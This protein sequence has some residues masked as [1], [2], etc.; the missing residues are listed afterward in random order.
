LPD[1]LPKKADRRRGDAMFRDLNG[2]YRRLPDPPPPPRRRLSKQEE[3]VMVWI[4]CINLV[5]LLIAPIGGATVI[6]AALSAF[7]H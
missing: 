1:I 5:I 2:Y 6:H 4:I 7:M 3:K